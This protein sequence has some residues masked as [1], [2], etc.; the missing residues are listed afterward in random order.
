[1]VV[2]NL[3]KSVEYYRQELSSITNLDQS[4][5]LKGLPFYDWHGV[6]NDSKCVV[7]T[8]YQPYEPVRT[9]NHAIG[10]PQKNGQP[11]PL[12]DYERMLFD[13]LQKHKHVWIKKAT[14]LGV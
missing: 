4:N 6:T 10:L 3:R 8:L 11:M 9:F 7:I 12:F 13:T 1:M 14:G 2:K 5:H